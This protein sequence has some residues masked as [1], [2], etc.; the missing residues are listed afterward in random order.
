MKVTITVDDTTVTVETDF[1]PHPSSYDSENHKSKAGLFEKL[2]EEAQTLIR[3]QKF[4]I[5]REERKQP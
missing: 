2:F 1:T 4:P 3:Y 5:D